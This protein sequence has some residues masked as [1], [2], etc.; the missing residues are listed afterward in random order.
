MSGESLSYFQGKKISRF[1][2]DIDK[3]KCPGSLWSFFEYKCPKLLE[4]M[5]FISSESVLP[6]VDFAYNFHQTD[7]RKV[8]KEPYFKH[9]LYSTYLCWEKVEESG[10][11]YNQNNKS[12]LI[13]SVLLHDAIEL[14]KKTDK[15]YNENLLFE[16]MVEQLKPKNDFEYRQ[17]KRIII[18]STIMV[19]DP[20]PEDKSRKPWV[21]YKI[22]GF[23]KIME[24][25]PEELIKKYARMFKDDILSFEEAQIL[26][27]SIKYIK[28][29]D[30]TANIEETI[31]DAFYGR[32]GKEI[33]GMKPLSWRL[34]VFK[35]RKRIMTKK[36]LEFALIKLLMK[37]ALDLDYLRVEI[38]RPYNQLVF[39]ENN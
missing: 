35:K 29:A 18:I 28:I 13:G 19:P 1:F 37:Q 30:E 6:M 7:Q 15:K 34:E 3:K 14:K 12:V 4:F 39:S 33:D 17:I 5:E 21:N 36:Y 27:D 31:D 20:K 9:L 16:K 22:N 11:K 23:N 8:T 26:A 32:D 38:G 25:T 10:N 2:P 24:I